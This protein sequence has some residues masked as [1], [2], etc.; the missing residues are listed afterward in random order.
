MQKVTVLCV[1][2]LKERFYADAAAEYEKRLSRYCKL[3][4]VELPEER[5]RLKLKRPWPGKRQRSGESCLRAAVSPLCA[6][7]E[8]CVPARSWPGRWRSGADR[9]KSRSYF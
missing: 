6:W 3:K 2:K 7:K 4:I 1:G 8:R 9:A 5:L